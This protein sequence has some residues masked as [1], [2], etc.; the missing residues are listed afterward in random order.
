MSLCSFW[1]LCWDK[2]ASKETIINTVKRLGIT[3][4]GL[5]VNSMQKHKLE[6]VLNCMT[7]VKQKSSE[8]ANKTPK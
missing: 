5:D 8:S 4:T 6:Q 3:V 1:Q 7:E 2:W